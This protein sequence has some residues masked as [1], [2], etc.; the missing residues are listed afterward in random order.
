MAAELLQRSHILLAL[1]LSEILKKTNN[2]LCLLVCSAHAAGRYFVFAGR[3]HQEV[4]SHHCPGT[5]VVRGCKIDTLGF[6][7]RRQVLQQV[8]SGFPSLSAA[9]AG[10]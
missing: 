1:F 5:L 7:R 2:R 8:D 6:G 4:D 3:H 9:P 10:H